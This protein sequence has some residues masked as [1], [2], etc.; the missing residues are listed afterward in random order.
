M[1]QTNIQLL[2]DY[3]RWAN[4][5]ILDAVSRLTPEQLTRD[6]STSHHS[7]QE[8]LI[9]ILAAEWIWLMRC[10]GNSPNALLDPTDFSGLDSLREKWAEVEQEQKSFVDGLTDESLQSIIAYTNTKGERWEYPLW[11][12]MQHVVNH[13]SYHRG[14]A[15]AML[16]Q[17]GAAVVMTDLLVYIDVQAAGG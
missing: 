17:L 9:H 11:Q 3:N 8:T 1:N 16:R 2:Y 14:Q 7:V 6:L 12:I 5:Q 13:S 10:R 15:T 4:A